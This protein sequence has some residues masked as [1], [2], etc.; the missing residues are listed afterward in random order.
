MIYSIVALA[1]AGPQGRE[2]GMMDDD[3]YSDTECEQAYEEDCLL[4]NG[5]GSMTLEEYCGNLNDTAYL[6]DYEPR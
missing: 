3:I 2:P 1:V 6:D 5:P 4:Q